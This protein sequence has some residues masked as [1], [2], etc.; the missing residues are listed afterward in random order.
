MPMLSKLFVVWM[1]MAMVAT[2][3]V[4]TP[5][6]TS[7]SARSLHKRTPLPH[8]FGAHTPNTMREFKGVQENTYTTQQM[9]QFQQGHNDALM[10]CN[11]VIQEANANPPDR[12]D[13]IFR[14]YF[15]FSDR[16]LVIGQHTVTATLGAS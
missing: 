6:I 13:R 11:I 16:Q 7:R 12:F 3:L 8:K 1:A 10:M 4:V 14:E 2:A 5:N 9:E 15:E